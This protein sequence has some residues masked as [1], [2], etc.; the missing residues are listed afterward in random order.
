MNYLLEELG[1]L[2]YLLRR[3]DPEDK[4]SRL[5]ELTQRG[6]AVRRIMRET[7]AAIEADLQ[8]ELGH[9]ALEQLR[10]LLV[11]LNGSRSSRNIG[12]GPARHPSSRKGARTEPPQLNLRG[13]LR[14]SHGASLNVGSWRGPSRLTRSVLAIRGTQDVPICAASG[15]LGTVVMRSRSA[16]AFGMAGTVSATKVVRPSD[17]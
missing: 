9:D 17:H 13:R 8:R 1:Q 4:R 5:M 6:Y 3:D 16:S 14:C 15:H 11:A 10:R 2:G 7:V 12:S